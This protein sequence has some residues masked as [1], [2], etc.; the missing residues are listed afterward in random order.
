MW[1]V[2]LQLVADVISVDAQ[3]LIAGEG[4]G[5]VGRTVLSLPNL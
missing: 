1:P 3:D 2:L 4:L 5:L